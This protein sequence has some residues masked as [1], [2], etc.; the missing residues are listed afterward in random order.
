MKKVVRITATYGQ[1]RI[2]HLEEAYN[3]GDLFKVVQQEFQNG[4]DVYIDENERWIYKAWT[5]PVAEVKGVIK[6]IMKKVKPQLNHDPE[7]NKYKMFAYKNKIYSIVDSVG[8]Y[9]LVKEFHSREPRYIDKEIVDN[10]LNIQLLDSSLK[11]YIEGMKTIETPSTVN[12]PPHYNQYPIE[13]IDMMISIFGVDKT[14][15]FCIMNAYKY[16]MR[17]GLKDN[18]EQDLAKEKWY[19]DKA[20]ELKNKQ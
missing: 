4:Q 13:T 20:N 2:I 16:R 14:I 9:Y 12:H 3:T 1:L 18:I 5:E 11:D 8:S 19:L 7:S 17:L 15:D 6:E 10:I